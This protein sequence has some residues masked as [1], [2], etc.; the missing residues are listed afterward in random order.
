MTQ[1][2]GEYPQTME[3]A[4]RR[5]ESGD[6]TG[7]E[8]CGP[9]GCNVVNAIRSVGRPI[10]DYIIGG[11]GLGLSSREGAAFDMGLLFHT[12]YPDVAARVLAAVSLESGSEPPTDLSATR[13]GLL[14]VLDRHYPTT[15]A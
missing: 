9:D 3:E 13:D 6:M 14:D 5:A 11:Q 7:H 12:W 4:L 15:E 10:Q 2:N 8:D 1:P